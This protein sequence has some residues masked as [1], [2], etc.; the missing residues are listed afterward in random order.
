MPLLDVSEVLTDPDL[1]DSFEVIRRPEVRTAVGRSQVTPAAAVT[2]YGVVCMAGDADL[3]RLPEDERAGRAIS[4][5]TKYRL[6]GPARATGG[7]QFQP[8]LVRWPPSTGD[9]FVVRLVEPYT[10]YG[11]GFVEAI[12]TS[13]QSIEQP[14]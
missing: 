4:I 8:D 13:L 3:Q 6:R 10:R 1:A 14:P 12:A 7:E 11:A 2:A 5:V 9:L